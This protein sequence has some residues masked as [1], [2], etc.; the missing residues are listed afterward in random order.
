MSYWRQH[1]I[2]T[3]LLRQ[4]LHNA[5]VEPRVKRTPITTDGMQLS[6][7]SVLLCWS[8]HHYIQP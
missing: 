1:F 8:L 7:V 3:Q 4:F 2:A 5:Y 6:A